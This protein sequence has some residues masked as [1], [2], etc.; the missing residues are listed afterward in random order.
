MLPKHLRIWFFSRKQRNRRTGVGILVL[1][2][3]TSTEKN[4]FG[5]RHKWEVDNHFEQQRHNRTAK[6]EMQKIDVK[7]I[8]A[9]IRRSSKTV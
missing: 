8:V 6:T 1:V 7:S 5:Q 3:N 4:T 2:R 9:V